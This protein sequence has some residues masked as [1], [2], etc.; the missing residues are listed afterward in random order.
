MRF[1]SVRLTPHNVSRMR[2]MSGGP[3]VPVTCLIEP[4]PHV[5]P[6]LSRFSVIEKQQDT[7]SP[8]EGRLDP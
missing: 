2:A 8:L 5:E 4:R 3:N 6:R 7:W 1:H